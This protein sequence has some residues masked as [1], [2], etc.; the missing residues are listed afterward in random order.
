MR[1]NYRDVEVGSKGPVQLAFSVEERVK[2]VQARLHG[3]MS[4]AVKELAEALLLSEVEQ[5]CVKRYEHN[6]ERGYYGGR[7][8]AID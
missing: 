2:Q 5:R 8:E 4:V 3:A 6:A 7:S 1:S